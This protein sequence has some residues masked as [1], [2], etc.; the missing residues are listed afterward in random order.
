MTEG[1]VWTPRKKRRLVDSIL[2]VFLGVAVVSAIIPYSTTTMRLLTIGGGFCFWAGLLLVYW[3]TLWVRIVALVPAALLGILLVLPERH[4]DGP[5]LRSAYVTSLKSYEGSPYI[6]GGEHRWGIDC[7]GLT[8]RAFVDVLVTEGI[9]QKEPSLLRSALSLW[10]NDASASAMGEGY[11]G[12]TWKLGTAKS[13]NKAD[14]SKILPGDLAVTQGGQ[15]ILAY[16]G[17][18][19]GQKTW[20]QAN[21][22]A[23]KVVHNTIPDAKDVYFDREARLIRWSRIP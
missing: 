15:H 13:L 8:R 20:I 6:W 17:E 19:N 16:L 22:L 1:N 12:K 4:V 21:P 9:R 5:A 18:E 2:L 7:S 3:N 11:Q 23:G 10:W 14:Y